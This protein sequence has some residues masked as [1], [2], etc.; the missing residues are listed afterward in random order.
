M[1]H[2]M[3]LQH[4]PFEAIREGNKTIE[5]RLYDEKRQGVQVG[6]EI[7]FTDLSDPSRKLLTSVSALH[8]FNN[9]GEMFRVLPASAM[10]YEEGQIPKTED[11]ELYYSKEKQALYGVIGIEIALLGD[12]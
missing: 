8:R 5:L 4:G 6:D 1:L 2:K 11:M 9:F 10:G 3:K 7:E 12:R